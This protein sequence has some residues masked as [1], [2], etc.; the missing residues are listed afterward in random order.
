[1]TGLLASCCLDVTWMP[2]CAAAPMGDPGRDFCVMAACCLGLPLAV[3]TGEVV[4]M[5]GM[6]TGR[7]GENLM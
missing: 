3:V 7:E 4:A 6:L 1:M 5:G 2:D